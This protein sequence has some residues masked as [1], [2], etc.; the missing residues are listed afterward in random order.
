MGIDILWFMP[1]TPISLKERKGSLGSYYAAGDY[2]SINPEFGTMEDFVSLV[3]A[4]HQLGF[5]VIIDWV[6]NHTG[7]DH[8][9]T[10]SHPEYYVRNQQGSFYEKNGWEDVIDL[11]HQNPLMQDAM[12]DAMKYWVEK[13]DIDGFRQDMAGSGCIS[14]VLSHMEVI[15]VV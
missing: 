12:I 6:A 11:D 8:T 10:R 4:A 14:P 3:D 5:K 1:I 2:T 9:W 15:E 7:W 13:F